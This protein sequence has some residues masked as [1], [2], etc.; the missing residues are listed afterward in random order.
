M[1]CPRVD[2]FES[3]AFSS[4]S[5]PCSL[6]SLPLGERLHSCLWV[7]Q[8]FSWH[9]LEQYETLR[10]LLRN[11]LS[12]RARNKN[13]MYDCKFD[14]PTKSNLLFSECSRT[15]IASGY[16]FIYWM[17]V[18]MFHCNDRM[19]HSNNFPALWIVWDLRTI[20]LQQ[21]E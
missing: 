11:R 6:C 3:W 21:V 20:H 14:L 10:H 19:K 4:L 9:S 13:S 2:T 12:C 15:P 17:V 7:D 16:N 8:S 18:N 1:I 5:I